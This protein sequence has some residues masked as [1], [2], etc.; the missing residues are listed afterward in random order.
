[1]LI[2]VAI[3]IVLTQ[4]KQLKI[5]TIIDELPHPLEIAAAKRQ[6]CPAAA[7]FMAQKKPSRLTRLIIVI[8][9]VKLI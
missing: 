9:Y 4:I 8:I 7:F 1:M 5:V 3:A 2:L 6:Y